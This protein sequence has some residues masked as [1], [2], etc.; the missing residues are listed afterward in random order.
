MQYKYK[1]Q[2]KP[3]CNKHKQWAK[4]TFWKRWLNVSNRTEVFSEKVASS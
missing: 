2:Y 4:N 3:E 1:Q